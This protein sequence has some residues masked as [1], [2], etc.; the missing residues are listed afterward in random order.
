M[1][2]IIYVKIKSMYLSLLTYKSW[3]VL[4]IVKYKR[5]KLVEGKALKLRRGLGEGGKKMLSHSEHSNQ[6]L[7][8]EKSS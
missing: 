7:L 5:S 1:I 2:H 4:K 8:H 6:E 3:S